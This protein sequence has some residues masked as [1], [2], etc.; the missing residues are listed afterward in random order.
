MRYNRPLFADT[1]SVICK[2]IVGA[3]VHIRPRVD[4]GIDPYEMSVKRRKIYYESNRGAM[5]ALPVAEEA[6]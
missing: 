1:N 3:D 6:T 5:G 4:V 2:I